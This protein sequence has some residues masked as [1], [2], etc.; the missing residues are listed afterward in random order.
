[1]KCF[2]CGSKLTTCPLCNYYFCMECRLW[3][4]PEDERLNGGE[5]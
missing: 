5:K 4:N 3:I 1:M 2:F